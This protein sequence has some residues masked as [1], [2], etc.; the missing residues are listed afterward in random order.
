MTE[1][2]ISSDVASRQGGKFLT[3]FL[4]EEEYGL[5]ILKVQE[6]IGIMEITPIPNT[7]PFIRGVVNLRG[8]V[9]PVMDL[10]VKFS[11]EA[12]EETDETCIIV[13]LV[14]G[15]AMGLVVDRVSEVTD[16]LGEDVE[17]APSFGTDVDTDYILGIA[18]SED[19]VR[20]LLDIDKVLSGQE[21]AALGQAAEK[22]ETAE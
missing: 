4:G 10:R 20:M 22:T 17:D 19:R 13:V 11:M 18:K 2:M 15:I 21:L 14:E 8:K 7:P 16:I 5:E 3:L 6:I 12:I 9:I 1:T